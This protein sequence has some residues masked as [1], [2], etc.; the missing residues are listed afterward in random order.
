V[1][2]SSLE[3][4]HLAGDEQSDASADERTLRELAE[5][6]PVISYVSTLL[7]QAV[8]ARAS[9]VHVEPGERE[10]TVR[11]RI[12]GV[13]HTR[14]TQAMAR[15]PAVSSRIK[16]IAGLD[17]AERRLPQDGRTTVRV[18]GVEMDIRVS[19]IPAVHGESLVLRL[20]P[21]QRKDLS[22]QR[23]GMEADHLA[24]FQGW[25]QWPNGLILVT[26]PTGSGKSTTLYGALSAV[27]DFTRKI[28]TVEDP[29]ELRLPNVVQIQTQS[30]IGYTFARA[31][32]SILR[33]DPDIIMVGEIRD[34]ETAEIAIQASLTGHLVLAT[35][36]TNDALSAVTRLVDMGVEPYLVAASLRAVMAQRLVRSLCNECAIE[37][38][39]AVSNLQRREEVRQRWFA[40]GRARYRS[41]VGCA[42]C[43][44]TGFR[45]RL[46]IYELVQLNP[47]L[48]HLIVTGAAVPALRE[49]ADR[50]GRR[51]LA[52]DGMLKVLA[53]QT[54]AEEVI[55]ACGLTGADELEP[56]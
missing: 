14:Q 22:L 55:R 36:H 26:G 32:R 20:L 6:A 29:V 47:E 42:Q 17:I 45:G 56:T 9:D 35:L 1:L 16:L 21:K 23:L 50:S 39:P 44:S 3:R 33:H 24:M 38:Q 5:D 53:G 25:L 10:F 37:A 46:G 51:G 2:P 13:L 27:N 11:M 15:F 8:D 34:R 7:A 52:D 28:V 40:G 31:L 19:V 54:T 30:E 49:L 43:Q 4:W 18:S 12:D 41:S 48:Q